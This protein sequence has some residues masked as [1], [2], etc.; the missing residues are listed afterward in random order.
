MIKWKD[1]I[2]CG[3]SC[4][5]ID[6]CKY[7]YKTKPEQ[8]TIYI[9]FIYKYKICV[10]NESTYPFLF[11]SKLSFYFNILEPIVSIFP[12]SYHDLLYICNNF[13]NFSRQGHSGH[14]FNIS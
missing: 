14:N 2:S 4:E 12:Q 13:L 9:V 5:N 8:N 10:T 6:S 3:D 7:K 11:F 1:V